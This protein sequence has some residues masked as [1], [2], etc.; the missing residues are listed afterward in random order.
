MSMRNRSRRLWTIPR[1]AGEKQTVFR[2]DISTMKEMPIFTYDKIVKR[3]KTIDT[4]WFNERELP[5]AFYEVE[6]STNII[7]SLNK[8]FELQDFRSDFFIV[9]NSKRKK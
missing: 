7:N 9:A 5:R 6:H 1:K 3:A 2:L 8:F 4:V